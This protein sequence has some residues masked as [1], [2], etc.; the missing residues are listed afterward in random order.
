MKLGRHNHIGVATRSI[1]DSIAYYR[2]IMGATGIDEP[3]DLPEQ[4]VNACFI[5]TLSA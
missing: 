3:F 4:G 1:V 2:D 5:G